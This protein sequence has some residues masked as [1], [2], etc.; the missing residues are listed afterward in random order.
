MNINHTTTYTATTKKMRFLDRFRFGNCF[1]IYYTPDF[2]FYQH[3]PFGFLS[4]FSFRFFFSCFLSKSVKHFLRFVFVISYLNIKWFWNNEFNIKQYLGK[5]KIKNKKRNRKF[6]DDKD[7]YIFIHF[8]SFG[9]S[10]YVFIFP[11]FYIIFIWN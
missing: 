5:A 6:C 3:F 7:L 4:Q 1:I 2:V 11:E 8:E 9:C 10:E